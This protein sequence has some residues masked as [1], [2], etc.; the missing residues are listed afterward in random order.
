MTRE[1]FKNDERGDDILFFI[2]KTLCKISVFKLYLFLLFFVAYTAPYVITLKTKLDLPI[3]SKEF[4][5]V[6]N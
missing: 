3:F 1:L 5:H 4:I 2:R 6:V